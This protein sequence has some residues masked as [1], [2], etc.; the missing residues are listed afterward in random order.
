MNE[1]K[2]KK[3]YLNE[4][5]LLLLIE[6]INFIIKIGKINIFI[7]F[8]FSMSVCQRNQSQCF[9]NWQIMLIQLLF[10]AVMPIV[11]SAIILY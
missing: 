10:P 8:S 5:H 3:K 2:K 11:V 9:V 4:L 7:A 6:E 1:I